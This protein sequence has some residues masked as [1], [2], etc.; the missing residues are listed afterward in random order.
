MRVPYTVL[1]TAGGVSTVG[2][3]L[4]CPAARRLVSELPLGF[5]A[6]LDLD[7]ILIRH[8]QAL[9]AIPISA[10]LSWVHIEQLRGIGAVR[11]C[12][13][14]CSIGASCPRKIL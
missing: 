13:R 3:R 7:E 4:L 6:Y 11:Q 8:G 1:R 14:K 10:E 9:L 5:E 2:L 12:P